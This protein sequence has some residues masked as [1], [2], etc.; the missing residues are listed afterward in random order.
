MKKQAIAAF[1]PC[2]LAA[3]L[4]AQTATITTEWE[5][6]I[7][8]QV[9]GVDFDSYALGTSYGIG[10]SQVRRAIKSAGVVTNNLVVEPNFLLIATATSI[11][12]GHSPTYT[13]GYGEILV[14]IPA[15]RGQLHMEGHAQTHSGTPISGGSRFFVDVY[16]DG[17]IEFAPPATAQAPLVE[18]DISIDSATDTPVSI[19]IDSWL[20][21]APTGT[22][23]TTLANV[24]LTWIPGG[25]SMYVAPQASGN[26]GMVASGFVDAL[27]PGSK[28][29]EDFA[30]IGQ[31]TGS[32][33]TTTATGSGY[34]VDYR[35]R[36]DAG[37]ALTGTYR[38][39]AFE[40]HAPL[41][42]I[43][44]GMKSKFGTTAAPDMFE[45]SFDQPIGHWGAHMFDMESYRF[46]SA[47]LRA[48]D[49]NDD[50]IYE[51]NVIYPNLED[52]ENATNNATNFV[53]IISETNNIRKVTITV[54]N[55][56]AASM[57]GLPNNENVHWISMLDMW[58]GDA[59]KAP[60][61]LRTTFANDN[62]LS[63]GGTIY[64]DIN[65]IAAAGVTI[66]SLDLNFD[67]APGTAG[68]VDVYLSVD[69]GASW[70]S[71]STGTV[72]SA[73][74]PGLPSTTTLSTPI[75]FDANCDY[76]MAIVSQG[77]DHAYTEIPGVPTT[78]S[79]DD[80][81]LS[82]GYSTAGSLSGTLF[83]PLT[84]NITFHYANG[85]QCSLA[86]VSSVG[87]G[88]VGRAASVYERFADDT[89]FNGL[90]LE[91]QPDG[92]V[93]GQATQDTLLAIGSISTAIQLALSDDSQVAIGSRGLIVGS[94]GWVAMG[95][96]NTSSANPSEAALLSNPSTAFYTWKD[97]NPAAFGSGKV[98]YEE[99][100]VFFGWVA[101]VTYDGVWAWNT[102]D[103]HTIQFR[104]EFDT[105]GEIINAKIITDT[106]SSSGSNML[107]GYSPGG[108]SPDPGQTD[109]TA[110]SFQTEG[111]DTFPLQLQ[112][113]GRPTQ[114]P[115]AS[116][117]QV[118]TT[119]V[120][121]SAGIHVGI[122]GLTNPSFPLDILGMSGCGLHASM[123]VIVG[124]QVGF[125]Q[126]V[127]WSPLTLPALPVSFVG[128]Q[129]YVQSAVLGSSENGAF[130]VG[131][132]T[133]NGLRC[134]IGS[135]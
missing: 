69:S 39:F 102:F 66:N 49:A 2:A 124:P 63:S 81:G 115:T 58:F 36:D 84:P 74:G 85:G 23:T 41:H 76:R 45:I 15:G 68:T 114:G 9:E 67:N 18:F 97:L 89:D 82:G 83:T 40:D 75:S 119:N 131:A 101:M 94:N 109:F 111:P 3:V 121:T 27:G 16:A 14:M 103:P 122:V 11:N 20:S 117:F 52:G 21:G 31:P 19:R 86:K 129:F 33:P 48:Y 132:L 90:L 5:A 92:S 80:L 107:V 32:P 73:A 105:Q 29:T 22:N 60:G 54:G 91:P 77:L 126:S 104:F 87:D 53:G 133:S 24:E 26:S 93:H 50:M 44:R 127:I 65:C 8:N 96:G 125:G 116:P 7:N 46:D 57:G 118:L 34:V 100:I 108:S 72:A 88:C 128:F 113:I 17:S 61:H 12:A 47:T 56:E 112:A 37:G 123:D 4:S 106:V 135:L 98:F 42:G 35:H 10:T 59:T 43:D 25:V 130:G 71:V 55:T 1:V 30:T 13:S 62:G 134:T 120:P 79:N 38:N 28:L 110:A 51:G 99:A 70:A 95:G 64:F 78:L 6:F